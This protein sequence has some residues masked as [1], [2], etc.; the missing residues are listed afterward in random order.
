MD[1]TEHRGLAGFWLEWGWIRDVSNLAYSK[2]EGVSDF[3]GKLGSFGFRGVYRV[4]PNVRRMSGVMWWPD[5]NTNTFL[6]ARRDFKLRVGDKGIKG[7]VPPDKEP[8]VVDEFKREVP[9]WGGMDSIWSFLWLFVI[10]PEGF[11]KKVFW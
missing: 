5:A 4:V 11:T 6:I 9:L 3:F 7:F 2:C 8:G 1:V 10:L